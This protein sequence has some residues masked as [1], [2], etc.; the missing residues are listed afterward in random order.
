MN[1]AL[2]FWEMYKNSPE[3][4]KVIDIFDLASILNATDKNELTNEMFFNWAK[5]VYAFAS[6]KAP[7]LF[8]KTYKIDFTANFANGA[9]GMIWD[10]KDDS[11]ILNEEV[12]TRETFERFVDTYYL[13]YNK[14][15]GEEEV[16]LRV[17]DY[18][19]KSSSVHIL[20]LAL[21]F[22]NPFFVPMLYYGR[23]DLV[24]SSCARLGIEL[25]VLPHTNHYREYLM[26]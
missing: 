13:S 20:S 18:R 15:N 4:K 17:D 5:G 3:G 24:Q 9:L 10:L 1:S 19:E 8:P 14:D 25:P 23:F 6:E 21:Y 2:G 7:E 11:G 16:Y 22:W 26:Y 12:P